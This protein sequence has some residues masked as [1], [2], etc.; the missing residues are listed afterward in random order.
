[1]G[2]DFALSQANISASATFGIAPEN[3]DEFLQARTHLLEAVDPALS[4]FCQNIHIQP[5]SIKQILWDLWLPLAMQLA[6]EQ[7]QL[8][9]TL[10]QGILGGQGTGKTTMSAF[11]TLILGHLGYRTLSLSLDDLY[12]TY[13]ERLAL[14]KQDPRFV[15]RGPPGTHD[16]E[17]GLKVLDELR[18]PQRDRPIQVPRFDK[19]AWDGA[20]DRIAPEVLERADIVL[21]EGWFVGV[22]PINPQIFDT[23]PPPIVTEA[24]IAFARDLNIRLQN[25]LPL[26][27]R[28]DRLI[29]LYPTDYRLSLEWRQQA[30][31][32]T[33]AIR[34]AGMTDA[35]VEEF[36]KY[37][38]RSL[39]PELYIKPLIN[40]PKQ[41]DLVIEINLDRSIGAVYRPSDARD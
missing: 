37:F 39:H 22:R 18:Q 40:E 20:G 14:R 34:G 13:S 21:F 25:Y 12:K 32:Q 33:I 8:G 35:E 28:L 2:S 17:L 5:S 27:E 41:V 6:S 30:E 38:W 1:M 3:V 10:I 16:I 24:D 4:H 11:L 19:S 36:V 7:Q 29:V 9:R 31:H 15:W 23:A 26:W